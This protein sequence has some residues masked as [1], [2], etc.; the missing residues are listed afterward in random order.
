MCCGLVVQCPESKLQIIF[1]C[2]RGSSDSITHPAVH[3]SS[4]A[5]V[6]LIIQIPA[7]MLQIAINI[8]YRLRSVVLL[9]RSTDQ[10]EQWRSQSKQWTAVQ[11][12]GK[13]SWSS[14]FL[15]LEYIIFAF[16]KPLQLYSR[17]LPVPVINFTSSRTF[18]LP[19][20]NYLLL[21]IRFWTIT[22][23]HNKIAPNGRSVPA[24]S[25]SLSTDSLL[26]CSC[27]FSFCALEC[28]HTCNKC[29]WNG[30]KFYFVLW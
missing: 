9:F 1:I 30:I 21:R 23:S 13:A 18:L 29:S 19:P 5:L 2:R 3:S 20:R 27:S 6:L 15:L 4:V 8:I 11:M 22:R 26:S 10:H 7:K 17:S 24:L 12:E 16:S 25:Y 14:P 28:V